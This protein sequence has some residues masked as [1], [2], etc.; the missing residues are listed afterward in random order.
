MTL[1]TYQAYSM[2]ELLSRIR[3]DLGEQAIILHTRQFKR[4][5]LLGIGARTIYE[6][7]ASDRRDAQIDQPIAKKS[8]AKNVQRKNNG[9]GNSSTK[10]TA[11]GLSTTVLPRPSAARDD[12]TDPRQTILKHIDYHQASNKKATQSST[13]RSSQNTVRA[14]KTK[15]ST[16]KNRKKRVANHKNKADDLL[17]ALAELGRSQ[18][19]EINDP[20]P[21]LSS[22]SS[23]NENVTANRNSTP[24]DNRKK[25]ARNGISRRAVTNGTPPKSRR[26]L[27]SVAKRFILDPKTG[28]AV[29]VGRSGKDDK[30]KNNIHGVMTGNT[31]TQSENS[32]TGP[33]HNTRP[34]TDLNG[35]SINANQ[36]AIIK[37]SS[38]KKI[39]PS[40]VSPAPLRTPPTDSENAL[41]DEMA[42]LRQLVSK[43]LDQQT[44]L[45]SSGATPGQQKPDNNAIGNNES[46]HGTG[47]LRS[48]SLQ[49]YYTALI[50]HEVAS[51]LAEDICHRICDELTPTELDNGELVR[52]RLL[53]HL[54]EHLEAGDPVDTGEW[55]KPEDGRPLTMAL[56]GATG[57]GKTTTVAKLAASYTL[58]D[59]LRVGLITTDTYRIAAVEQLRTYADIIGVP[60]KVAMT[61][62]EIASACH[63]LRDRDVILI[64]TAGR[65]PNDSSRIAE[66]NS[67]ITAARPHITHLVLSSASSEQVILRTIERFS[68]VPADRVIF[69]KLDEAVNF[70]V[71]VN[72][73]RKV[74][75]KLSFITTGQEVPDQIERGEPRRLARLILGESLRS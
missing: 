53:D 19:T 65:S 6:V 12:Q 57:V 50:E 60:L 27:S 38:A 44:Q 34:D 45:V 66:I 36:P 39:S 54:A 61:P 75:K 55:M 18:D 41:R 43:V 1:R 37:D 9:I 51:E 13:A 71:I 32:K 25:S 64:D 48:E 14:G 10:L 68:M 59:N 29:P 33:C 28:R 47:E 3:Q 22:L 16:P 11:S 17:E 46:P 20:V 5:G 23:G 56:I 58:R 52:G 72:V 31:P 42:A 30:R 49:K 26:P 74:G 73:M 21:S 62:S 7:T 70:G 24:S 40:P 8:I 69:T 15:G 4:G 67:F 63:A 35:K 2:A